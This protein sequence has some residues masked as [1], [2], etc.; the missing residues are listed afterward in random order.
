MFFVSRANFSP[1]FLH[2]F[3][4]ARESAS[5]CYATDRIASRRAPFAA[6]LKVVC[7]RQG[8][9]TLCET[10]N[11]MKC[12]SRGVGEPGSAHVPLAVALPFNV[13][14]DSCVFAPT[15]P[16]SCRRNTLV[17]ERHVSAERTAL[18]DTGWRVQ[19]GIGTQHS[20]PAAFVANS[21]QS[22]ITIFSSELCTRKRSWS[23][24]SVQGIA[25]K[26][27]GSRCSPDY[28]VTSSAQSI[29]FDHFQRGIIVAAHRT[30]A[31][32]VCTSSCTGVTRGRPQRQP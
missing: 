22:R 6:E 1:T 8:H 19:V 10:S 25:S 21:V 12:G 23:A 20:Q 27:L 16:I 18:P 5:S 9:S 2:L 11:R 15:S 30:V 29:L 17:F 13:A 7:D 32:S 26:G 24:N 4:P 28:S 3:D 31:A 14:S